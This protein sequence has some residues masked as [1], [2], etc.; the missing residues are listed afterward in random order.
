MSG[1]G[2]GETNGKERD[3]QRTLGYNSGKELREVANIRY[4]LVTA[5]TQVPASLFEKTQKLPHGSLC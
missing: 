2:T 5:L 1:R 4:T 3:F